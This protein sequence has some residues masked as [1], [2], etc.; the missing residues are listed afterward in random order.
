MTP[1]QLCK[2]ADAPGLT[3]GLVSFGEAPGQTRGV[4]DIAVRSFR[5]ATKAGGLSAPLTPRG[6]LQTENGGVGR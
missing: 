1:N 6:Y 2:S 3:R 5:V 4:G